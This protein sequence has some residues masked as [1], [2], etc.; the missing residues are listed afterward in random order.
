MDPLTLLVKTNPQPHLN[1][2]QECWLCASATSPGKIP[3]A[4]CLSESPLQCKCWGPVKLSWVGAAFGT[5]LMWCNLPLLIKLSGFTVEVELCLKPYFFVIVLRQV[6]TDL[7][8]HSF[9][10]IDLH[11]LISISLMAFLDHVTLSCIKWSTY[12]HRAD[13]VSCKVASNMTPPEVTMYIPKEVFSLSEEGGRNCVV[14]CP[15]FST[16]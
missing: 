3:Q 6:R 4:G 15:R 2:A 5:L 12:N 14:R 10:C 11:E 9:C 8:P 1:L 16:A 7:I 13:R